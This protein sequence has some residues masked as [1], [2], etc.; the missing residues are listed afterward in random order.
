MKWQNFIGH[1][2]FI[3]SVVIT[4]LTIVGF[5][6]FQRWRSRRSPLF[7][8]QVGHV[9]GQQL[10]ARIDNQHEELSFGMYVM[11][12]ALPVLYM[13]WTT[14]RIDWN[15]VRFGTGYGFWKF[16]RHDRMRQQAR[17]GLLAERVTGMQLNRLMAQNCLVLH[18]LPCDV[19]NID[20]V[21]VAPGAVFAVET[22]SF[23]KPKGGG[24]NHRVA[25]DGQVLRF[26]DFTNS[27]ALKQADRNAQWLRRFLREA[28]AQDIPVV[29][30][31]SLP[32][33][34]IERTDAAKGASVRVFTPM[35][36]GAEFLAFGPERLNA[37]LRSQIASSLA[38][39]YPQLE[40]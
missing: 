22:K 31:V 1:G 40:A 16:Q 8:K 23:R 9:P 39:K 17:D 35:G 20:H 14:L 28:L 25:Y 18:D 24:E 4:V 32:G 37:T 6:L 30:A 29:P 5:R 26:P 38:Q 15:R 10:Q 7:G 12:L 2:V 34:Y 21:V 11:M 3:A 36:R 33:W 13:V 19:G 27:E